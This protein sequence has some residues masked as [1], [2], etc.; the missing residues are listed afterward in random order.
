MQRVQAVYCCRASAPRRSG[1]DR[2]EF[3][4]QELEPVQVIL[5]NGNGE[6]RTARDKFAERLAATQRVRVSAVGT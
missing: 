2:A 4:A 6:I 1:E 3:G 5:R